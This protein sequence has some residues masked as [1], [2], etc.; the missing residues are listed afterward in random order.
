MKSFRD[1]LDEV[2]VKEIP[3]YKA[4]VASEVEAN[5]LLD[6]TDSDFEKVCR[7]VYDWIMNSQ[8]DVGELCTI[9]SN[10]VAGEDI[11]IDDIINNDKKVEKYVD[12]MM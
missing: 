12:T 6:R 8:M 4:V 7:Y 11:T 5:G 10:G 2:E 9:L 3:V 1:I